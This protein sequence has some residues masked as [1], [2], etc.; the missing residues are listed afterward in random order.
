M[1]AVANEFKVT[2]YVGVMLAQGG[3][4]IIKDDCILFAPRALERAMGAQDVTIPFQNVRM[5]EVTGTITES[6]QIKTKERVHR[7]VGS[8]LYKILDLIN[9]ALQEY[10]RN[11]PPSQAPAAQEPATKTA[12]AA[13]EDASSRNGAAKPV[14]FGQC[15]SCFKPSKPHFNFCPF[16]KS[17][18]KTVCAVCRQALEPGWKFCAACGQALTT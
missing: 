8:D 16:C 2:Y 14:A 1:T 12:Q 5:A 4:L 17:A 10:Q 6:L 7:F 3:L 11:P 15:P 18:I 9:A 13:A